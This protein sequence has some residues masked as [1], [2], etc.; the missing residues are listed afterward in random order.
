MTEQYSINE[1]VRLEGIEGSRRVIPELI[2]VG[3]YAWAA[4]NYSLIADGCTELGLLHWRRGLDPRPDF[5]T[6]I[7][8]YQSLIALA[9]KH[10]LN[11]RNYEIPSVYAM[12]SLMERETQIEFEDEAYHEAH[13]WPCYQ[14]CL[15]HELHD[16]RPNERH[17]TLLNQYLAENDELADR[18]FLTYFELLGVR[19]ADQPADALVKLA[20]ANWISR[21]TDKFFAG[22]PAFDGYGIM[23][24]IY[25]DIYLAAVMRKIG[26]KGAS[27]HSW[28]WQ[29][30]A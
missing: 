23:N 14:C 13:R 3:N 22:G 19:P 24:D 20:E 11:T 29:S 7:D 21:K 26:W 5:E 6:A 2:G 1:R 27:V 9:R 4:K 10:D 25:V 30:A 17:T 18:T 15:V 16:Q 8:A 28:R 12:L